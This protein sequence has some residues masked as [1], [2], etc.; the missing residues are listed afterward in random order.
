MQGLH[1]DGR[2]LALPTQRKHQKIGSMCSFGLDKIGPHER[3]T[4]IPEVGMYMLS[5]VV[6]LIKNNFT[7]L[8]K[9]SNIAKNVTYLEEISQILKVE[10]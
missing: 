3:C 1:S 4:F 6:Q 8:L 9:L 10:Y 7:E 2:H 5:R